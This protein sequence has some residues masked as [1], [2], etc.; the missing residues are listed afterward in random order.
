MLA[1]EQEDQERHHEIELLLDAEAPGDPDPVR[2]DIANSRHEVILQEH[3]IGPRRHSVLD[4]PRLES[5]RMKHVI[6]GPCA[7]VGR[8]QQ[9]IDRENPQH[10]A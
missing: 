6:D 8:K 7:E 9:E 4:E 5:V 1:R 10:A 3:E 2:S